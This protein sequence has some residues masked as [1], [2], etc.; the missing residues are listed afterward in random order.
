MDYKIFYGEVS[1]IMEIKPVFVYRKWLFIFI[2][3]VIGLFYQSCQTTSTKSSDSL[4]TPPSGDLLKEA[5]ISFQQGQY[6]QASL[7]YSSYIYSPF[8]EKTNVNHALYQLGSC[9][10][11]MGQYKDAY[12]TLN[13][14]INEHPDFSQI[15]EAKE[16]IKKCQAQMAEAKQQEENQKKQEEN[17]ITDLV[18]SIAKEPGNAQTHYQ[19]ADAYWGAGNIKQSVAEYGIAATLNPNL[20]KGETLRQRVR[21]T[22]SGEF[23]VRDPQLEFAGPGDVRVVTSNMEKLTESNW[24]GYKHSL[25]ITGSVENTGLKNAKNVQVEVTIFDFEEHIQGTQICPIGTITAGEQR[26]FMVVM[27]QFTG[28]AENIRKFTTKVIY[29]E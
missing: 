10:F 3:F 6:H 17:Q 9:H 7:K 27:N 23:K 22:D 15:A 5:D 14:L 20:L 21:I 4:I 29:D 28:F 12:D 8:G 11:L 1:E 25:R 16:L 13:V 24:L 26:P 2:V 18:Q 19:L